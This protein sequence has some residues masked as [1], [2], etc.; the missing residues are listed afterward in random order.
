MSTVLVLR[1]VRDDLVGNPEIKETRKAGTRAKVARFRALEMIEST[2]AEKASRSVW[3]PPSK[4]SSSSS[5]SSSSGRSVTNSTKRS[6][7]DLESKLRSAKTNA[8][9]HAGEVRR[10]SLKRAFLVWRAMSAMRGEM[11]RVL[12]MI[13]SDDEVEAAERALAAWRDVAEPWVYDESVLESSELFRLVSVLGR[14]DRILQYWRQL[15]LR[16][17]DLEA[18]REVFEEHVAGRVLQD[19]LLHWKVYRLAHHLE[20][21]R[22]DLASQFDRV[23]RLKAVFVHL[24]DRARRRVLVR[25]RMEAAALPGPGTQLTVDDLLSIGEPKLDRFRILVEPYVV[26]DECLLAVMDVQGRRALLQNLKAASMEMGRLVRWRG[27]EGVAWFDRAEKGLEELPDGSQLSEISGIAGISEGVGGDGGDG[28]DDNVDDADDIDTALDASRERIETVLGDQH[29]VL[30]EMSKLSGSKLPRLQ[31][32]Q[33]AALKNLSECEKVLSDM[34]AVSQKIERQLRS[35]SDSLVQ[36]EA[37][38]ADAVAVVDHLERVHAATAEALDA[39]TSRMA[40]HAEERSKIDEKI[41]QWQSKVR[42]HAREVELGASGMARMT[43]KAGR[44]TNSITAAVKLEEARD[45]LRRAE[46]RKVDM[47]ASYDSLVAARE[48]AAAVERRA[49]D[50]LARGRLIA[51]K[52]EAAATAARK[53]ADGLREQHAQLETDYQGLVPCLEKLLAAVDASDAATA[54]AF[55]RAAELDAQH[56]ALE[57]TLAELQDNLQR[58]EEEQSARLAA[59]E[60]LVQDQVVPDHRDHGV[61]VGNHG[62]GNHDG[63]HPPL[64]PLKST[65]TTTL[66]GNESFGFHLLCR[67]RGTPIIPGDRL[68]L[69]SADSYHVLVRARSCLVQWRSITRR[70]LASRREA[71]RRFVAHVAPAPLT[72]WREQ[73]QERRAARELWNDRRMLASALSVW[74]RTSHEMHRHGLLV[75]SCRAVSASRTLEQVLAAWKDV[76]EEERACRDAAHRRDLVVRSDMFAFW[77]AKTARSS[78]LA[79][80]LAPVCARKDVE[81]ARAA[82]NEWC[83]ATRNRLALRN[84]FGSACDLWSQRIQADAYFDESNA[85]TVLADCV[86]AWS[87]V[88]HRAREDRRLAAIHGA[89]E[90]KHDQIVCRSYFRELRATAQVQKREREAAARAAESARDAAAL[91]R[92]FSHLRDWAAHRAITSAKLQVKWTY[93]HPLRAAIG[94]WAHALERR[95]AMDGRAIVCDKLRRVLVGEAI[96]PSETSATSKTLEASEIVSQTNGPI[97]SAT[98]HLATDPHAGVA[99]L[100]E[101]SFC[102]SLA[103]ADDVSTADGN[104]ATA[105]SL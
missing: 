26:L 42:D 17:N 70:M 2:R 23:R 49:R 48:D 104:E 89:I 90:T 68:L 101:L 16:K 73:T 94:A 105:I 83:Q 58:L 62:D 64:S 71:E 30:A 52:A 77:R 21:G 31:R 97:K 33:D 61:G 100:S 84:A 54:A 103:A 20:C 92:C 12:A 57:A 98:Y 53:R 66:W 80:R 74:K 44:P 25:S 87:L 43:G 22:E 60:A 32:K 46:A 86:N 36:R 4:T 67:R 99:G 59:E 69:R 24:R 55:E 81:L 19:A 82:Y 76:T 91:R 93:D 39:A 11:E 47:D 85:A 38:H 1:R 102:C 79:A 51:D 37:D 78:D 15:V 50:E 18:R 45:R 34:E 13:E 28:V 72:A 56:D 8:R 35:A 95:R 7:E 6:V 29:A 96:D 27:L 88:V 41:D 10:L 75:A 3:V 63:S 65:S 14:Q 9:L 5:S 40:S